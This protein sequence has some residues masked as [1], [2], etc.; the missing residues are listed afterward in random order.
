MVAIRT[1]MWGLAGA[2][3]YDQTV[4]EWYLSEP[5]G[6]IP[7]TWEEHGEILD[8]IIRFL[9]HYRKE[10]LDQ[11]I[12]AR[13]PPIPPPEQFIEK[14]TSRKSKNRSKSWVFRCDGCE[15]RMDDAVDSYYWFVRFGDFSGRYCCYE[16]GERALQ[17]KQKALHSD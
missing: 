1:D 8:S 2:I 12:Q 5:N 6:T 10:G 15:K 11:V 17:A 13:R 16:H 14:R 4:G 9:Q 3:C 7:L